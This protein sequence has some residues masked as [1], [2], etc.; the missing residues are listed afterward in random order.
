MTR[1]QR[2]AL[3]RFFRRELLPLSAREE[4]WRREEAQEPA[5]SY[6]VV[7]DRG[8]LRRAD[9]ELRLDDSDAIAETL[10]GFWRG[11]PLEGLGRRFVALSPRFRDT[12]L[13]AEVSA[14][15]YEMF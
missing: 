10:D 4:I 14:F 5:P 12:R 15:V 13:D 3:E 9:F 1:R 2:R 8:P 6:W 7:R 11:G